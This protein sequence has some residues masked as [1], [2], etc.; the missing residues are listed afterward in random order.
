VRIIKKLN[1]RNTGVITIPGL[2]L[3]Q[4]PRLTN[5][6]NAGIHKNRK[7]I[8]GSTKRKNHFINPE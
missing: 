7:K 1:K 6:K 3:V 2:L 8:V 5:G 4:N